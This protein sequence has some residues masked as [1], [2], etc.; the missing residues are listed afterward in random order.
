MILQVSDFRD[1]I[2]D[3]FV[4]RSGD[5]HTK[6]VVLAAVKELPL[7]GGAATHGFSLVFD[8]DETSAWPQGLFEVQ[9]PVLGTH[10][11]F[12]VPIGP[13]PATRR[14]RYQALFN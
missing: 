5:G 10:A 11:I 12:L 2:S 6:D 14:M 3:A 8:C 13:D 1:R 4:F 7:R 9:H